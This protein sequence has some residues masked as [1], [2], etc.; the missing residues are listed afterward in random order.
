M[1][2]SVCDTIIAASFL[3]RVRCG[4]CRGADWTHKWH[5]RWWAS[6]SLTWAAGRDS[7]ARYPSSTLCAAP[8][9]PAYVTFCRLRRVAAT[10]SVVML[11]MMA[12]MADWLCSRYSL[13]YWFS[14]GKRQP[15]TQTQPQCSQDCTAA[16]HCP[17]TI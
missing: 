4:C 7:S 2:R 1:S 11:A 5:S 8:V 12:M 9:T 3:C 14:G 13:E 6:R 17:L 15:P 16:I 10:M